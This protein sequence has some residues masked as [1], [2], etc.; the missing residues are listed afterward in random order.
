M[1]LRADRM[2]LTSE[3]PKTGI[4]K[5]N[6]RKA[7]FPNRV[8]VDNTSQRRSSMTAPTTSTSVEYCFL[9]YVPNVVSNEGVSI[10]AIVFSPR[11][12]EAGVCAMIY[13]P[14]W[15]TRVRVLDPDADLETLE[16]LLLEIRDR[17]LSPSD[18]SDMIHQM[19]DSFSTSFRYLNDENTRSTQVLMP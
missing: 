8:L 15:Q 19:E 2:G 16:A 3:F 13:A 18:R 10:A 1:R 6:A 17:L 11:D 12:L 4:S 14:S 9:N 7:L 5:G